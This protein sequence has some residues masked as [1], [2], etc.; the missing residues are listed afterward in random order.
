MISCQVK[1]IFALKIDKRVPFSLNP[2]SIGGRQMKRRVLFTFTVALFIACSYG[3]GYHFSGSGSLPAGVT[4]VFIAMLENRSAETGV[5]TTFTNDLIYEFTRNRKEVLVQERSSADGILTGTIVSLAV[6]NISR[7]SVSTAT[8]RR[9]TGT[10]TLRLESPEG[11]ILWASGNIVERQAYT[12]VDGNK[13]A[14]DQNKSDA[15]AV[16]SSRLAESAFNRMTDDF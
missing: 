4:R 9:V 5:E 13:T 16:L 14:T 7:S 6:N 3:C 11:R 8:E 1:E 10:L 15:I 2:I 12:V